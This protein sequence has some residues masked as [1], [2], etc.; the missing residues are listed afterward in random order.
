MDESVIYSFS[1]MGLQL[2]EVGKFQQAFRYED[3]ARSLSAKYPNTFGARG[4]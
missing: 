1:I 3:L 2:G 4:A